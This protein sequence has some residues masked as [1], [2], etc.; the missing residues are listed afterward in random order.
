MIITNSSPD[1]FYFN[2]L[3]AFLMSLK[4]NSPEHKAH[5]FLA[6]YP[7]DKRNKLKEIFKDFIFENRELK[8]IDDRGFSFIQFRAKLIKE[9]FKKHKESVAW[10][11]TDVIVRKDLSEFLQIEPHQLKI[12]YRGDNAPERV[13]IN[14]GIFNIGYSNE[15]HDFICDWQRRIE[16][17]AKWGMGQLEFWRAYKEHKDKIELVKMD[18]KFNDLGGDDRPDSFSD[19]SVMWHC[20]K[21]HFKNKKFQKEYKKYLELSKWD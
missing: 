1:D 18:E 17:N 19:Q 16:V 4:I 10:I 2:Q 8:M 9:C 20:K 15:T 3:L 11:D 7:K 12:L 21:S 5:I 14:A 6:N 13:R